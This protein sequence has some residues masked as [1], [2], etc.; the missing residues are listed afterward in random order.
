MEPLSSDSG[1][2]YRWAISQF[3]AVV[4]VAGTVVYC[5]EISTGCM[6]LSR[7]WLSSSVAGTVITC[8]MRILVFTVGILLSKVVGSSGSAPVTILVQ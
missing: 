1:L 8:E 6:G 2:W 4:C 7:L 3:N 5:R